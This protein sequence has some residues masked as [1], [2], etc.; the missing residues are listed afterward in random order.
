MI[1]KIMKSAFM[2]NPGEIV[3]KDVPVPE[4]G[5]DEVLVRV[6]SVGICGSDIHYY[7]D[8]RIGPHIV[9]PPF[10]LG[11]EASGEVVKIG[12]KVKNLKEGDRVTMEPGVP[13]CNCKYCMSGRYNLCPSMIF[14]ATPPVQ[15]VLSE[16]INHKA[17]FCYKIVDKIS[18]E[19]GALAEPL[20]V[21]VYAA[22]RAKANPG[23][24]VAIL[25]AGTIGI[26]TLQVFIAFGVKKI[27]ISDIEDYRLN[28]ARKIG[29]MA[30]LNAKKDNIKEEVKKYFE[31]GADITLETA[32]TTQTAKDSVYITKKGGT[33]IQIG[34]PPEIEIPYPL[35]IALDKELKILGSYRYANCFPT[36]VS[37]MSSGQIDVKRLIS[38]RFLFNKTDEA[39]R[40][41]C[42]HKSESL[43]IIINFE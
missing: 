7:V 34:N 43:K 35:L 30:A 29:V 41:A 12:K 16:F 19:E 6:R 21:A 38:H 32:G 4:P 39:F 22:L 11:H 20:S 13:C 14:W 27:I 24:E 25:G 18:F 15:G 2:V 9:K 33:I 10:V 42:N 26:V 40:F 36:A 3:I 31:E 28:L 8:G 37:M 5:F 23:K 1:P 17:S